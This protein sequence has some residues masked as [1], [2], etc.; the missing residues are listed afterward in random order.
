LEN[1]LRYN[2]KPANSNLCLTLTYGVSL[3][4]W[5]LKGYLSREITYYKRLDELGVNITIISYGDSSDFLL[6]TL[7]G[8][9]EIIPIYANKNKPKRSFQKALISIVWPILNYKRFNKIHVFKTNQ[10]FGGWLPLILAAL[11]KKKLFVRLGY[12]PLQNSI[13]ANNRKLSL[14][15]IWLTSFIVYRAADVILVTSPDIFNFIVGKY[16]VIKQKIKVKS[17]WVNTQLFNNDDSKANSVFTVLYV[18]RLS[19]EKNIDLLLNSCFDLNLKVIIIGKG[20]EE[21]N[22]KK[23]AC[24]LNLDVDFCGIIANDNLISFYNQCDLFCLPSSYEGSPKSLIEAMSCGCLILASDVVGNST[25]LSNKCN[26]ILASLDPVIF[27]DCLVDIYHNYNKY[28][29][30]KN[31]ARKFAV[32]SLSMESHLQLELKIINNLK[33]NIIN[34]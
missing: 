13:K 7:L 16:L 3:W 19:P 5:Y 27:R 10:V 8:N 30:L 24:Q 31:S 32:D 33:E 34:V 11:N 28:E 20:P 25:L 6:K 14:A 9:I 2:S 29:P 15:L 1:F 22:L 12:E 23:L 17:N 4:D 26:G 18:G 21:Y